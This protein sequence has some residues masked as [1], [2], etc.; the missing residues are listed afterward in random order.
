[1]T[2]LP[3]DM[4]EKRAEHLRLHGEY[5]RRVP[6]VEPVPHKL[7]EERLRWCAKVQRDGAW[8]C[9]RRT[10]RRGCHG[11]V[12]IVVEERAARRHQGR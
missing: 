8:G 9:D 3:A 1:L 11:E 2:Y 6:L 5:V 10:C 4:V 7:L 12:F